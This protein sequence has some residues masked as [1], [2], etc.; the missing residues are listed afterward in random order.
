MGNFLQSQKAKLILGGAGL[1][2][3]TS[4]ISYFVF[5]ALI[6]TPVLSPAGVQDKR[7]KIDTSLPKTEECPLNGMKYTKAE[8]EVW[9]KRRPLTV[10]IENH[11]EARPQSGLSKA[12]IVYEAIAE[13]GVTRFLS[14]FYCGVAAEETQVGPVRSARIY[15]MDWASEYGDYPLYA[16]VGGANKPGPA[17]ALGAVRKY[18]WE[19]YNDLNQ[20]S[21]G[22]PT[23]WRDYERFDREVATEHTMYSK[24]DK[25][26][27]IAEK[28]GL[29]NKDK[30][31]NAWDEDFVKWTFADGKKVESPTASKISFPFWEGQAEYGV[32]WIYDA[33]ANSYKRENGGKQHK[34]MNT[35]SQ[36]M[37]SNV[38]ILN[39]RAKGPIDELKHM[40][41]DT[42]GSGKA[43]VFQNGNVVQ[44]TW[45]K[46]ARSTRTRFVDAKGKE[47]S[48]VRGPIWIE[49]LDPT[50][51]VEY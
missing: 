3:L 38:V 44:A 16:H 41:Y 36:I 35:D 1:Y 22:F 50:S 37:A 12:D 28:R 23:F 9:E 18:G 48:F 51:K 19:Q 49:V 32:E 13:G 46:T 10:S 2:L 27:A 8:R 21:I 34:D 4:G 40:L 42:I 47:I 20:F 45:K 25:L 30:K 5:S 26:W 29:S 6:S 7:A 15:F 31:G 11:E 33:E 39:T 14:V 17:D 43:L 24:T